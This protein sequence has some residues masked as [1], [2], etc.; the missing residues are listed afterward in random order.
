MVKLK[1]NSFISEN[2][3]ALDDVFSIVEKNLNIV[4]KVQLGLTCKSMHTIMKPIIKKDE[5]KV[6]HC[7]CYKSNDGEIFRID[8]KKICFDCSSDESDGC[9]GKVIE[10]EKQI[11]REHIKN[12]VMFGCYYFNLRDIDCFDNLVT[13]YA[14]YCVTNYKLSEGKKLVVFSN[15]TITHRYR[16]M[17]LSKLPKKDLKENKEYQYYWMRKDRKNYASRGVVEKRA[18]TRK[19]W[20]KYECCNDKCWRNLR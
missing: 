11:K 16:L 5:I 12:V 3:G 19:G 17:D 20:N 7:N 2:L 4:D 10:I 1:M 6:F 15:K 9:R 14:H 18:Y 8:G 13:N